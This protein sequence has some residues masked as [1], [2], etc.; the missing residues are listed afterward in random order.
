MPGTGHSLAMLGK[1]TSLTGVVPD[2]VLTSLSQAVKRSAE[3]AEI[4]C[5][6][7]HDSDSEYACEVPDSPAE[8]PT[9]CSR[10]LVSLDQSSDVPSAD[11]ASDVLN[12]DKPSTAVPSADNSSSPEVP[13]EI[14]KWLEKKENIKRII[15]VCGLPKSRYSGNDVHQ[16]CAQF[17]KV[18][19]MLILYRENEALVELES[20]DAALTVVQ[21]SKTHPALVREKMVMLQ[22]A[23]DIYKSVSGLEA[24]AVIRKQAVLKLPTGS[25]IKC[26]SPCV[27]W[28]YGDSVVTQAAERYKQQ[29]WQKLTSSGKM[30]VFWIGFENM[31][32][33]QLVEKVSETR[34]SGLV[35]LPDVF[36]LHLGGN[37]VLPM[38]WQEV[39]DTVIVQYTWLS[40]LFPS[41][42]IVWSEILTRQFWGDGIE[43]KSTNIVA[44]RINNELL[45]LPMKK[46]FK[47]TLRHKKLT[48]G[49]AHYSHPDSNLLT[50]LGIDIFIQDVI[51]LVDSMLVES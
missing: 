28:V 40:L 11:V 16:I 13:P 8:P 10:P 47:C 43:H 44:Q 32:L 14:V 31:R 27:V 20:V 36:I 35:P 46:R 12:T 26:G 38:S 4:D 1:G 50:L 2:N 49:I 34:R 41:S 42:L 7:D 5:A 6:P 45:N 37:D 22:F 9:A 18:T 33:Q 19:D 17:G 25:S 30:S 29:L 39:R 23:E 24:L 48:N 21:R 51:S 15:H 3:R